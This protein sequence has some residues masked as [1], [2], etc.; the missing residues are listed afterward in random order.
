MILKDLWPM[1]RGLNENAMHTECQHGAEIRY[2]DLS[3]TEKVI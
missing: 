3:I 1:I 2:A